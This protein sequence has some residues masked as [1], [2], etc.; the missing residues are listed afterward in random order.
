VAR[1]SLPEK[2]RETDSPL[3]ALYKTTFAL[4]I[5][6]ESVEELTI[7][8]TLVVAGSTGLSSLHPQYPPS[9]VTKDT[10]RYLVTTL[11][12]FIFITYF[13]SKNKQTIKN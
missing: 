8:T 3:L 9:N 7:I 12:E 6:E 1:P 13:S 11:K 2:T 10:K 4:A 5:K